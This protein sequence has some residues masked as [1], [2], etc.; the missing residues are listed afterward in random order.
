M[1]GKSLK[2]M[3][4]I[5]QSTDGFEPNVLQKIVIDKSGIDEVIKNL[6]AMGISDSTFY[7][8]LDGLSKETKRHFGYEV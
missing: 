1:F 8:S 4:D 6:L 3:E 2:P 7:P 5:Y